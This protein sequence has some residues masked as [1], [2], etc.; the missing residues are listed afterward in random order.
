[1]D[2]RRIRHIRNERTVGKYVRNR[3]WKFGTQ[4]WA[5]KREDEVR[6]LGDARPDKDEPGYKAR[7]RD[8]IKQSD[9][10]ERIQGGTYKCEYQKK[11]SFRPGNFKEPAHCRCEFREVF[12]CHVDFKRGHRQKK[13]WENRFRSSRSLQI[14]P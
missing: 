9:R 10:C 1:M 5:D 7:E 2:I 6:E 11:T 3:L 13:D 12:L 14:G 4:S 8:S